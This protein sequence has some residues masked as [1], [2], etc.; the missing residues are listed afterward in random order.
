MNHNVSLDEVEKFGQQSAAWWDEAGPF[1]PLHQLN[2][3]RLEFIVN[4]VPEWRGKKILDI[5]CGGGLLAE[6]MARLGAKVVAIDASAPTIEAAKAHAVKSGLEIDYRCCLLEE[7]GDGANSDIAGDF[8][9]VFAMEVV[10]HLPEVA[11]F[12]T[13]GAAKLK[14]GG[15]F[16]L[17]TLNRTPESFLIAIVGAEYILQKLPKGTH[18]Y[19]KFVTPAELREFLTQA[20]MDKV[21]TQG[22]M[23]NPLTQRFFL[24]ANARV[25]Y[26]ISAT[27]V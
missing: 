26:F 14:S 12:I 10:E 24:S 15:K 22:A 4:E 19:Q 20:D 21:K 18:A 25:N 9:A 27:K 6:P 8:D 17:S 7:L 13:K 5:G 23:F 1:A 16:F 11:P 3:V 2:R